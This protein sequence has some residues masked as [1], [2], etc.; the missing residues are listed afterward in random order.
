MSLEEGVQQCVQNA[1]KLRP[2]TAAHPF[3]LMDSVDVIKVKPVLSKK[4]TKTRYEGKFV[5]DRDYDTIIRA[6]TDAYDAKTGNLLFKFRKRVI[7]DD[8]LAI[9]HEVYDDVDSKMPP[10]NWRNYAAGPPDLKR[11]HEFRPDV[12]ELIPVTATKAK[13]VL[14]DGTVRKTPLCNPVRSYT[15]GYNYW[16]WKGGLGLKTGFTKKY[17]EKWERSVPFFQAIYAHFKR[18]LPEVDKLHEEQCNKH[19]KFTIPGTNLTTVAINVNYESSFHL[20]T[21]D[22]KDG[23]STL[24][25]LEVGGYDGGY[26][27]FP[28]YRVA[29]DIREGDVILN[30]SHLLYHGNSPITPTTEGGKRI[31]FVTY[32]KKKMADASNLGEDYEDDVEIDEED[33]G[34]E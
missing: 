24:T 17:P 5:T 13:I 30:Q 7:P 10:S 33:D 34:E 6:D 26:L 14:E 25:V 23:F 32:L 27:V 31:S 11:W 29:V 12:K 9:A 28:R 16:R 2:S 21:G 19:R 1:Q 18:E 3:N 4:D 15:A 20:D 22:L 8:I